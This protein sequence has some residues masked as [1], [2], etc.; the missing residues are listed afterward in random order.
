MTAAEVAAEPEVEVVPEAAKPDKK[1]KPK[2]QPR[3]NV[4]LWNDD[5]HT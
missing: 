1:K 2:R 3:Y 4:L 5:D